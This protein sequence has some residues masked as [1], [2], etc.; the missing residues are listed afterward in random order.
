MKKIRIYKIFLLLFLFNSLFA[1]EIPYHKKG[2]KYD[3]R[4]LAETQEHNINILDYRF[5][6]KIDVD[7]Q[8]IQGKASVTARSLIHNLNTITLHL[9]D[10][11]GVTG[12]TQNQILLDFDHQE[13]LLDIY[14]VQS[15]NPGE[16]FEVEIAYQ[17]YPESGLNFS[18]HQDQPV[19]WSL[20]EPVGAREWF[21]CYDLPSDKATVEMRVTVPNDMMVA[22]NGS[23]INVIDNLDDTVTFIWKENYPIATYLI[24]IAATNYETFSD[25][26]FSG[27]DTME[28]I[29]YVYPEDLLLAQGDFSITVPMIEFYSQAFGE[30]PFLEE[31]YGMAEIPRSTA[32]EHQTCTSYPSRAITGNHAYDWLIAHELAHQ[33]WGDLVTMADWADIWLNEG[34]ATYS[35]A[36]WQEHLYGS[37]GLKARM[38][39]FKDIYFNS[40]LDMEHPIYNP[41]Q[42][43]LFCQIEYQKAAWVVHMLRFVVGDEAFWKILKKYAHDYAY[44]TVTTDDFR[45]VCEEISGTT[46]GWFFN[47]WI[48]EAGYPTYEFGWGPLGQNGVRVAINQVQEDFPTFTM[49]VELQFN[50]PSGTIKEIVW[51]D[52]KNNTFNF[53][54]P[55]MPVEVI[56]DPDTWIL[57]EVEDFKKNAKGRR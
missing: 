46:L 38:A 36:L 31:K 13:D 22:S 3:F 43:H 41:P 54:F 4:I 1:Q 29:Y 12:I 37:A 7:S 8:Y 25:Y 20:D 49:P 45:L 35:D 24:S 27:S 44:S 57:C 18:Y 56:F 14:L 2:L 47:Q 55:E 33:W 34:F 42:G 5:D 53:L 19:V 15:Q 17:G 26:Y 28:V 30:Y 32:M 16:V 50:F 6:W 51:V 10:N 52:E 11:M 39:D 23:L 21:P 40:H 9:A 48:F